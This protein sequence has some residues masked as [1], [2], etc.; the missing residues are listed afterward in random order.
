MKRRVLAWCTV[1]AFLPAA[2]FAQTA[3]SQTFSGLANTI[4]QILNN[5]TF[6]LIALAL[7]VYFWG[8][9]SAI[10]K[11][12]K[13]REHLREHLLWGVAIIFFAVSIW[14]IVQLLQNSVLNSN[15]GVSSESDAAQCDNLGNCVLG[16][17]Q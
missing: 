14:G 11:G 2:A 5:A 10:F 15:A 9:S 16:A 3:T 8:V 17:G 12:E 4:V 6:D 1:A 13:G 7:V